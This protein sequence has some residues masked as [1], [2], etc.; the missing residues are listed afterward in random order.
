MSFKVGSRIAENCSKLPCFH[1]PFPWSGSP[2]KGAALPGKA[3]ANLWFGYS[4][5]IARERQDK[6]LSAVSECFNAT[7]RSPLK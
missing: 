5:E 7:H 3:G 1:K 2:L 4:A 6:T